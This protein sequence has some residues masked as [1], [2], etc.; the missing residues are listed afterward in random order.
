MELEIYKSMKRV[1]P[2]DRDRD[3]ILFVAQQGFGTIDQL[4]RVVW[5]KQKS[6][7]YTRSRL[8]NLER[9][10]FFKSLRIDGY[11][12]KVFR[13]TLKGKQLVASRCQ[14]IIPMGD[15]SSAMAIHQLELNEARIVLQIRGVKDWRSAESLIID[16]SFKKLGGRHVPD[17]LYVT[18]KGIRTAVEYDRT[19]RKKERIKERMSSYVSELYSPDRSFDRLIYLVTPMLERAYKP[20]F[21][22]GFSSMRDRAVLMTLPHFLKAFKESENE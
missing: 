18:S 8:L 20:L 14:H 7:V 16:P 3:A 22:Q 12:H 13:A 4:W 19:M 6:S 9:A 10:G 5:R 1:Q 17:G 2:T 15:L 11:P 21:E